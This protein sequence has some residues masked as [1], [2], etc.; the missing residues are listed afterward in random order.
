MERMARWR[1]GGRMVAVLVV[2]AMAT[3]GA[4]CRGSSSPSSKSSGKS[5]A[6]ATTTGFDGKTITAREYQVGT[7]YRVWI[8]EH[9][10][11]VKFI[12]NDDSGQVTFLLQR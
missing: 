8:D 3:L 12:V 1:P 4:S 5:G 6:P 2:V 10:V 9:D 11:P 7:R